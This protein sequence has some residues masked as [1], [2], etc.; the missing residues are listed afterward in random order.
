MR[1]KSLLT[2]FLQLFSKCVVSRGCCRNKRA[3]VLA[4]EAEAPRIILNK[5]ISELNGTSRFPFLVPGMRSSIFYLQVGLFLLA[6]LCYG[7]VF[8]WGF[9]DLQLQSALG[10]PFRAKAHLIGSDTTFVERHCFSANLVSYD[11]V[12][13]GHIILDVKEGSSDISISGAPPVNEPAAKFIL[14]H[15]CKP[16]MQ[17]EYSIL[18]DP[19]IGNLA[20]IAASSPERKAQAL[21][22]LNDIPVAAGAAARSPEVIEKPKKSS[23]R[24][25]RAQTLAIDESI[26][27]QTAQD[28]APAKKRKKEKAAVVAASANVLRLGGSEAAATDLQGGGDG[29]RLAMSYGLSGVIP[30]AAAD[31][32]AQAPTSEAAAN[33]NDAPISDAANASALQA[34]LQKINVLENKTEELRKL[35]ATQLLALR[36]A[37]KEPPIKTSLI[38]LYVLLLVAVLAIAWLIWRMR[39]IRAEGEYSSWQ[40][41]VPDNDEQDHDPQMESRHFAGQ[42][43]DDAVDN[44][45]L[46]VAFAKNADT[47]SHSNATTNAIS[48]TKKLDKESAASGEHDFDEHFYSHDKPKIAAAEELSDEVQEAEFW[49]HINQPLRAIDIL[50]AKSGEDNPV[51]PLIW[52]NLFDLYR[53]VGDK[54]KYEALGKRFKGVFNGRVVPWD[55]P[56]T[57]ER[58]RGLEDFPEVMARIVTLWPTDAVLPFLEKLLVDERDGSREGFDLVAFRDILFL[59]NI[60]HKIQMLKKFENPPVAYPGWSIL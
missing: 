29:L 25:S 22:R 27:P 56:L 18:L 44:A 3:V 55:E 32:P 6:M 8:A 12:P 16:K 30:A 19:P 43:G 9:G 26:A 38:L 36:D 48:D 33:V 10:Q 57:T 59:S 37:E 21:N 11:G 23:Q 2:I 60:A 4:A 46:A 28:A 47:N 17:R 40:Q 39:K 41:I 42:L 53:V 14:T 7:S 1:Y 54:A 5:R 20:A 31:L 50:E 45:A 13:L 52:L 51:S 49:V 24:P 15:S 34:L 35:N 58:P